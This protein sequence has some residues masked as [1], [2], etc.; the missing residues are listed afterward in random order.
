MSVAA[1]L[2]SSL[3]LAVL[4]AVTAVG[5]THARA[6]GET[7]QIGW[8]SQAVKRTLPLSYLDQPPRDEGI[9]GAQLGVADNNTTGRFTGQSFALIE[10][11]VPE[12]SD[13]AAGVREL[14]A[15][16]IRLV[17]TDLGASQLL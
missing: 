1:P 12:N 16:G 15:K 2:S 7:V 8:L 11:I 10:A 5:A 13:A 9:Q 4:I 14:T 3:L 6:E 17:V